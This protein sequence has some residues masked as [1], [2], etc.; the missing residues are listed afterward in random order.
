MERALGIWLACLIVMICPSAWAEQTSPSKIPILV[1]RVVRLDPKNEADR[2]TLRQL[3]TRQ[4]FAIVMKQAEKEKGY[5]VVYETKQSVGETTA[6]QVAAFVKE[7]RDDV[8][9]ILKNGDELKLTMAWDAS[10][11]V[12]GIGVSGSS[13]IEVTIKCVK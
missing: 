5:P 4:Q 7:M 2:D 6:A 12:W 11:K 10:A 9:K 8:C 1:D 3:L 13:G